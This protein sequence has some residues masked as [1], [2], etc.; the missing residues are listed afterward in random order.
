MDFAPGEVHAVGRVHVPDGRAA[1]HVPEPRPP[2]AAY[3]LA[4]VS[5]Y[6]QARSDPGPGGFPHSGPTRGGGGGYS[7]AHP[8]PSQGTYEDPY[9]FGNDDDGSAGTP[10]GN[11]AVTPGY[12]IANALLET[13]LR[14][15][16]ETPSESDYQFHFEATAGTPARTHV[17]PESQN[18]PGADNAG[19][20]HPRRRSLDDYMHV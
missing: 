8:V 2:V 10:H 13:P 19:A 16:H 7:Q 3:D 18:D 9:P 6:A 1:W 12:A 17:H 20:E 14:V 5:S 4:G 15:P 11:N